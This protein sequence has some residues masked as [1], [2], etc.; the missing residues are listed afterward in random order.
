[1]YREKS[2]FVTESIMYKDKRSLNLSDLAL[3]I[4]NMKNERSWDEGEL[5]SAILL[6]S[7]AKKIVL[8]VLHKGTQIRSFQS[9]DSVT[10]QVIE[11]NLQLNYGNKSFSLRKGEILIINEKVNYKINSVNDSAFLMILTSGKEN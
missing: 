5:K 1:M 7:P 9:N 11:G 4:A 6:K 2:M 10:I 3:L 8:T